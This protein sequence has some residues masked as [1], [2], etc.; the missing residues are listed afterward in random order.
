MAQLRQILIG[1]TLATAVALGLY[2]WLAP[3]PFSPT[4]APPEEAEEAA[5]PGLTLRNVTLEQP[6]E[7]GVLLWRVNGEE[8]TYSSDRQVALITRPD[9]ELFQDGEAIYNVVAD[10]GQIR[11]NGNVILLQGNIVATGIKNGSVLRGNELVWRVEEDILIVRN[12]VTGTHP[13]IQA[14][15]DEARVLNRENRIDLIGNVVAHTVVE[16]PATEPRLKLQAEQLQW[17]WEAE[18]IISPK[19]LRVEQ[20]KDRTITDV[21]V[22]NQGTVRLDDQVA[23]L[24]GNVAMQ[25]LELPLNATSNVMEWRVAEQLVNVNQPLTVVHPTEQMR[26]TARRGNINLANQVVNMQEDVV[27]VG[28]RNQSR[29]TTNRLIWMVPNQTVVAD[30]NV[31]YRQNNPTLNLTGNRGTGRLNESTFVVEGG[32]VVTEIV[33]N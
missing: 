2:S 15:A 4:P 1:G 5:E 12:T 17:L 6:D 19:P 7:N 16:D 32:Q 30:G 22:G 27:A 8:V 11:E 28:Q 20:F 23:I 10:T 13:Q 21:L 26:V 9:G 25:M 18:R 14:T 29:L 31:N 24:Q 33:P 3:N